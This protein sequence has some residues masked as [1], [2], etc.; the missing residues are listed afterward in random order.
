MLL[1][2]LST[3][4]VQVTNN[5]NISWQKAI[6]IAAKPLVDNGSIE[7]TYVQQ[8]VQVVEE[9]GPYI[10]IGPGIA[11]AHSR[12]NNNVHKIG[13]SMLKTNFPVSL[14]NSDHPIS[15]WFVLAA[16]DNNSHLVLIQEL[17]EIL[18]DK[19]I[20]KLLLQATSSSQIL[21]II[22]EKV[23]KNR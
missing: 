7:S 14:V 11:L 2:M 9:K 16:T 15:L 3:K 1:D 22:T 18:T 10:N 23:S 13:L 19:H 5:K 20:V 6:N 4:T 8:M 12:P 21:S 17:M